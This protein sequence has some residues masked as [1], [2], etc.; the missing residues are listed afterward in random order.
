MPSLR[1]LRR[2]KDARLITFGRLQVHALAAPAIG[3]RLLGRWGNRSTGGQ[4]MTKH[5]QPK[6]PK[7]RGD[8]PLDRLR[9]FEA[10]RGIDPA[11]GPAPERQTDPDEPAEAGDL[12][13]RPTEEVNQG[14]EGAGR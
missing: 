12:K 8:R 6:G 7:D 9:E 1:V 11:S 4:A 5:R 14:I 13:D 3:S 2:W 10:K